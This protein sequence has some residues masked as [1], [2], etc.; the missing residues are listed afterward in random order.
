ME[1]EED[2]GGEQSEIYLNISITAT[3]E[4]YSGAP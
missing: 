4:H 1:V 2:G 3:K